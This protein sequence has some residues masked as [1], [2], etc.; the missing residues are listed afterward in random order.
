MLEEAAR[1]A[2]VKIGDKVV[3]IDKDRALLRRL[4]DL[5]LQGISTPSVSSCPAWLRP[6]RRWAGGPWSVEALRLEFQELTVL[7]QDLL[8]TGF[9]MAGIDTL[10]LEDDD[11]GEGLEITA[12]SLPGAFA[13]SRLD[14]VW[15]LG[16]HR[17]IQG[18]ARDAAVYDRLMDGSGFARLV[19]TDE[20]FNVANVGHLTGNPDH[21]EFAMAH[22]EMS[23][24]EFAAFNRAWMLAVSLYLARRHAA[25]G[26]LILALL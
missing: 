1:L 17:L 12:S 13:T 14:D 11:E 5:G 24:E 21:R 15:I 20:P 4:F 6:K 9:D 25:P 26:L 23:R 3:H 2:K 7:G 16:Q 18:D 10:L 19:L 22:G 8:D